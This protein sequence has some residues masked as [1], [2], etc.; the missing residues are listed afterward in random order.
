MSTKAVYQLAQADMAHLHLTGLVLMVLV[1]KG[2]LTSDHA[3]NLVQDAQR[4][5]SEDAPMQEAYR[6]LSANF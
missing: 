1:E 5:L 4:I 3:Q 6:L 2:I